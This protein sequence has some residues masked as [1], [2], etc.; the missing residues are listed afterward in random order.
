M[1]GGP[2]QLRQRHVLRRSALERRVEREVRLPRVRQHERDRRQRDPAEAVLAQVLR[3]EADP[4]DPAE[5]DAAERDAAQG[6]A[7]QWDAAERDTAERCAGSRLRLAADRVSG[8]RDRS[9]GGAGVR[10]IRP[11]DR[12]RRGQ[13]EGVGPVGERVPSAD[14]RQVT[15]PDPSASAVQTLKFCPSASRTNSM[16]VPSRDQLG[17]RRRWSGP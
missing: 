6:D 9:R 2:Q 10:A 3:G 13:A 8:C 16:C 5:W 14:A 11:R 17:R 1:T 12:D 7:A 15:C 4:A